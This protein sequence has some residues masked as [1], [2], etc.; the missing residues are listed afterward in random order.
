MKE[1]SEYSFDIFEGVPVLV[2]DVILEYHCCDV[3]LS[4][5]VLSAASKWIRL[6][7]FSSLV[8]SSIENY[9]STRASLR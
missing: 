7:F 5:E 8:I 2:D 6:L 1:K 3:S 9:L 4:K